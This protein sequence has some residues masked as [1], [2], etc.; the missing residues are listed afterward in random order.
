MRVVAGDRGSQEIVQ[1]G[2]LLGQS[3]AVSEDRA[4][5]GVTLTRHLED[6][7]TRHNLA[8]GHFA[9]GQRAGLVGAYDLRT[10]QRLDRVET[11]DERVSPRH[12]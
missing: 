7:V 3:C 11:A 12:P 2:I 9:N 10:A 1:H 4:V 8:R 5:G 6:A